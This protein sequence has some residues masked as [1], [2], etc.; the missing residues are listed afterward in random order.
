MPNTNNPFGL[1][2]L[3]QTL[4][5]GCPVILPFKKTAS[6]GTAIFIGDA[7]NQVADG[8]I[9]VSATPGTTLYSGVSLSYG[10]ANKET[11]HL[12]IVS[13]HAVFLAQANNAGLVD[14]DAGINAN[15]S[16]GAGNPDTLVSGHVIDGASKGTSNA[17]DLHLL[18]RFPTPTNEPGAYAQFLVVFNKHRMAHGVAGV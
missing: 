15:L 7:V 16:L 6:Y 9:E 17:L 18:G 12:V 14:A 10:K 3:M 1:R 2:C 8:S 4:G 13:P 11:E 5:G